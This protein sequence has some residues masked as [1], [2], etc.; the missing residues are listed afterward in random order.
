V[1]EQRAVLFEGEYEEIGQ[2]DNPSNYD[3]TRDG[4]RFVMIRP[5]RGPSAPPN[6]SSRLNDLMISGAAPFKTGLIL[7]TVAWLN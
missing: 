7:P 3:V 5:H 4:Q 6:S 2:P 1:A